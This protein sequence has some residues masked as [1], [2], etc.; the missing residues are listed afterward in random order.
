MNISTAFNKQFDDIEMPLRR[1]RFY[2][3]CNAC[4]L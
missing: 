3:P 2:A 1:R 4:A